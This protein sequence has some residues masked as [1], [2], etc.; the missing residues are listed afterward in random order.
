MNQRK[1]VFDAVR[2]EKPLIFSNPA[3]VKAL[4]K[5]LT[6]WGF[7][8][9]EDEGMGLGPKGETLIKGW[10][11]CVLKA[12]PDPDSKDGKPWTIGRGS[13]GPGIEPG[14]MWTQQQADDRFRVDI[15]RFVKEVN[16]FL[17]GAPTTQNQFDALVSFH[18][19][20]GAIATSTL[21]KLHKAGN[22]AGA[23]LEFA[24]WNKNDGKVSNGL[25]N[26]R[27]AEV[28]LYRSEA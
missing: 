19:N 2:A 10:E 21:G 15:Q 8:M 28:A 12:Y 11:K 20:T 22:F 3:N 25:V 5:L 27:K 18:Y 6:D 26:R 23:A 4:D 16:K 24:K 14:V 1:P 13:T 9:D 17:D 7:P